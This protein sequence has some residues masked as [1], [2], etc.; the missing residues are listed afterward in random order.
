[1]HVIYLALAMGASAAQSVAPTVESG[2]PIAAVS[3]TVMLKRDTPIELMAPSEISTAKATPGT[4][5]KM[6]VNHPVEV[7]GRTIIPVGAWA[8]GQVTDARAA[9]MVGEAGAMRAKLLRLEL[10]DAVI[11]LE[12][13]VQEKGTGAGSAAVAVLLTGFVGL[14][15]R[16]NNAKIKAGEIV[17]GFVSEDVPLDLSGP[18]ARLAGAAH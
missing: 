16:G 9:G 1:M 11:P 14:F 12:G 4:I 5:F 15:H 7:G 17:T 6:R 10:D 8:F 18:R 2:N 3:K 13:D